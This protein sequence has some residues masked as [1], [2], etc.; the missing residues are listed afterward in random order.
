[1]YTEYADTA[2]K[3]KLL[4]SIP[5]RF[6]YWYA[7]LDGY[8]SWSGSTLKGKARRYRRRYMQSQKSLIAWLESSGYKVRFEKRR[9]DHN[10]RVAII[11]YN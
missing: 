5:Q 1:M 9:Y 8:E 2:D 6:T 7:L 3:N 10:R 4:E 11:S